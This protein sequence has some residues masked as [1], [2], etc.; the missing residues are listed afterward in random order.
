MRE[1]LAAFVWCFCIFALPDTGTLCGGSTPAPEHRCE[2]HC[3]PHSG[4][5]SDKYIVMCFS[6]SS[7]SSLEN[8][9]KQQKRDNNTNVRLNTDD[10]NMSNTEQVVYSVFINRTYLRGASSMASSSSCSLSQSHW[11]FRFLFLQSH[12]C[13]RAVLVPSAAS[14]GP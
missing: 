9:N 13:L 6:I 8:T 14:S 2:C 5:K 3:F 1:S 4:T 12:P 11:A 10:S 7:C